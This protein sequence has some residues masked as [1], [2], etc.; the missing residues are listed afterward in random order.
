MLNSGEKTKTTTTTTI[1]FFYRNLGEADS[2]TILSHLGLS[3]SHVTDYL[4][5]W[6][7]E[8]NL[9]VR[10]PLKCHKYIFHGR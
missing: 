2:W 3:A 8:L 1:C 7:P 4:T 6:F 9:L 10:M 5:E